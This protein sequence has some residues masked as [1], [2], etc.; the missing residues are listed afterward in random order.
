M[1]PSNMFYFGRPMKANYEI[2]DKGYYK[3]CKDLKRFYE[4]GG[5]EAGNHL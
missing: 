5:L 2:E 1:K 3:A 4:V